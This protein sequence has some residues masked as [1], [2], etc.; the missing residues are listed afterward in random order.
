VFYLA[1]AD[2]NDRDSFG[3]LALT[4][5]GLQV[6]DRQVFQACIRRALPVTVVLAGGYA[7]DMHDIID[8]HLNTVPLAHQ[9][10]RMARE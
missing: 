9:L 10:M 3:R 2:P 4:K 8:I 5:S 6:R 7:P 1:G